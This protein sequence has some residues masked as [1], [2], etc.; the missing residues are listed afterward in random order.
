[1][2]KSRHL[3]SRTFNCPEGTGKTEI[4]CSWEIDEKD[5]GEKTLAQVECLRPR[6][7]WIG[8][9]DCAWQCLDELD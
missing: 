1:M 6:L 7:S 3:E 4:I 9:D 8:S 5:K 2:K